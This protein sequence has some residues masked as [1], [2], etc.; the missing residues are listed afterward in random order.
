MLMLLYAASTVYAAYAAEVPTTD[1]FILIK[2]EIFGLF[3]FAARENV[4]PV[5]NLHIFK[6][7]IV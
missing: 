5:T 2:N 6:T 3:F 7:D 4:L 1:I